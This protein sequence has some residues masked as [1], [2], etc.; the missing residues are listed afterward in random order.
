MLNLFAEANSVFSVWQ[1]VRALGLTAYILL[2]ITITL[3]IIQST[4][5]IPKCLRILLFNLHNT[6]GW[7]GLFLGLTHGLALLLD[8]YTS[9]SLNSILLPLSSDL[10]PL[11]TGAGTLTLY[12]LIL[13]IVSS[14]I[15]KHIGRKGWRVVHYF[16]FIGFCLALYHGVTLG[17]DTGQEEIYYMYIITASIILFMLLVK[18]FLAIYKRG[19]QREASVKRG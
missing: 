7:A 19:I 12:I 10:K 6:T 2:F 13:I 16:S 11:E 1:F 14:Y 5:L 4:Q 3:G 17:S 9:F 8:D 18:I 15:K